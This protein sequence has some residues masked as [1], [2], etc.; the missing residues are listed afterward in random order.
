MASSSPRGD[1]TPLLP[2]YVPVP[3]AAHGPDRYTLQVGG[4]R[5]ELAYHGP[6]HSPDNIYVHQRHLHRPPVDPPRPR[7][8]LTGPPVT[9]RSNDMAPEFGV[10]TEE[11]V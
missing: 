1:S 8:R 4:E 11:A 7:H 5:V 10:P 3:E 9:E 6:N 2:I